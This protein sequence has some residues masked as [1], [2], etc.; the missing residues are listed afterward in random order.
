[1]ALV[2]SEEELTKSEPDYFF[3]KKMP[4]NGGPGFSNTLSGGEFQARYA[5]KFRYSR[6]LPLS[7]APVA[8]AVQYLYAGSQQAK[9]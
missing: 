2:F 3:G 5:L 6:V 8:K 4:A 7:R 9:N 1:M